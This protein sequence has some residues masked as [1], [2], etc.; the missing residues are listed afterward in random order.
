MHAS[1][2]RAGQD[3]EYFLYW[4][5]ERNLRVNVSVPVGDW[6]CA[7]RPKSKLD[8]AFFTL[9]LWHIV[10]RAPT[11]IADKYHVVYLMVARALTSYLCQQQGV[12]REN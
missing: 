1:I 2:R 12:E 9:L 7:L 11:T 10:L 5:S 8:D 4:P 6:D 3:G